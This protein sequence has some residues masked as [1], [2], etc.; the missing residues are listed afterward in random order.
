MSIERI[1]SDNFPGL[2]RSEKKKM[3]IKRALEHLE[4]AERFLNQKDFSSAIIE[5]EEANTIY[6][7]DLEK[8]SS[9]VMDRLV[10]FA[11]RYGHVKEDQRR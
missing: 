4:N 9:R 5:Y 7:R 3:Y 1:S 6:T 10:Q 8:G 2:S 11:E